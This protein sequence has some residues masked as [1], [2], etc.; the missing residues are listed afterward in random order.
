MA[1]EEELKHFTAKSKRK[2]FSNW[3][4]NHPDPM[5]SRN[6]VELQDH[7]ENI[8]HSNYRITVSE[9][10]LNV[11]R[12]VLTEVVGEESGFQLDSHP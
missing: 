4:H 10:C 2:G 7:S 12:T 1:T 11:T 3:G 9:I 6:T 8:N 5:I